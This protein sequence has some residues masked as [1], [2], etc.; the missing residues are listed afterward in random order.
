M[1]RIAAGIIHRTSLFLLILFFTHTG[2]IRA[3][4][5]NPLPAESDQWRF[6]IAFPMIWAPDI[7]GK[8]RGGPD[9]DFEVPFEDVIKDLSFGIMGELYANRGRF[10]LAL[11]ANYLSVNSEENVDGLIIK[12][13][14][15]DMTMGVNEFL[16]SWRVHDDVR[17]LTGL[18]HIHAKLNLDITAGIG[19]TELTDR[20]NV[21]DDSTYDLLFGINYTHW[22]SQR[23]SLMLNADVA[24]LGDN[25]RDHSIDFRALYRISDLNNF[26]FGFRYLNIGND[27]TESGNLLK[28]DMTQVGP[29]AGWAFTF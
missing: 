6:T 24:A 13:I 11:R 26:W 17:V 10:G 29:S 3:D 25:D 16:A 22:F 21:I 9:L 15:T 1:H 27:S 5:G 18:R 8:V 28:V 4:S 2:E 23:W 19:S 12:R 14:G 20:I 7:N